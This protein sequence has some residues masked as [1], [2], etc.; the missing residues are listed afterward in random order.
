M[1]STSLE[2]G[3]AAKEDQNIA[4]ADFDF[5]RHVENQTVQASRA[6]PA[7]AR[8]SRYGACDVHGCRLPSLLIGILAGI[9]RRAAYVEALDGSDQNVPQVRSDGRVCRS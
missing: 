1:P 6:C 4:L 8:G 2:L 7:V 3:R 5:D 9:L